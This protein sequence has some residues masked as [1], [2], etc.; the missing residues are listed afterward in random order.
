MERKAFVTEFKVDRQKRVIEGYASTF[1][2][3]DLVNDVVLPGAYKHTLA[4]VGKIKAL[5]DHKHPI[6]K[7]SY[8]EEDSTGLFVRKDISDTPL[9][10]ETV[11][12]VE[13]GVLD[14]MSIGYETIRSDYATHSDGR[15]ARMLKELKLHEVSIVTFPANEA[16]LITG[17][18]S[19][20]D[21]DDLITEIKAGAYAPETAARLLH[22]AAD[23]LLTLP[24]ASQDAEQKDQ[25]PEP[26]PD[27]TDL[28]AVQSL[29]REMNAHLRRAA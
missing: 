10:N 16:A 11:T 12:L 6:G 29:I 7:L 15:K 26:D 27:T 17:V 1:G 28:L 8:A 5:R 13:D 22:Q 24:A 3:R 14:A 4:R 9:G 23:K 18:K 19:L 25:T 21:L 20:A 2:N